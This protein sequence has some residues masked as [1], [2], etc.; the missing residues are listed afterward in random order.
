MKE[1]K[2]C[3]VW[4]DV[5]IVNLTPHDVVLVNEDGIELKKFPLS[6]KEARLSEESEPHAIFFEKEKDSTDIEIRIIRKKYSFVENLPPSLSGTFYI[7]SSMVLQSSMRYD[8][9]APGDIIRDEKGNII[10][11]L[12]FQCF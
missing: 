4:H 7:V 8:L 2:D 11:C 1:W 12:N 10:G 5:K 6:G 3:L 9:L